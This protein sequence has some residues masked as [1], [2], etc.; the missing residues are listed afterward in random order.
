MFLNKCIY[1]Y[2]NLINF[3]NAYFN[4]NILYLNEILD[5]INLNNFY[6]TIIHISLIINILYADILFSHRLIEINFRKLISINKIRKKDIL[7][8][9]IVWK[10]FSKIYFIIKNSN[11]FLQDLLF[12]ITVIAE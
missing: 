3:I 2:R 10:Y 8:K 6:Y 11:K 9:I 12:T 5:K 4:I 7:K 1:I